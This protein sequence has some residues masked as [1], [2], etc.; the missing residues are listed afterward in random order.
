MSYRKPS[1]TVN[2]VQVTQS[3]PFADPQLKSCV[4][5]KGYYWQDP[6]NDNSVSETEYTGAIAEVQISE[7]TDLEDVVEETLIVEL[8][9]TSG[10]GGGVG[11]VIQLEK[12]A[13]GDYTFSDGTIALV[14]DIE[15]FDDGDDSNAKIRVGFLALQDEIV[16]TFQKISSNKE[17]VDFVG[18]PVPWN[19]LAFGAA[20]MM[21]NSAASTNIVGVQAD[22]DFSPA[23]EKLLNKD[24]Y[25]IAAM[26]GGAE[27]D[28]LSAHVTQMSLPENKRERIA[29][30]SKF[31]TYTGEANTYEDTASSSD[32]ETTSE[33]IQTMASGIGNRRFFHI[34]PDS[35]AVEVVA[36][37][38]TLYSAF[39][40]AVFDD[41]AFKARFISNT[42]INGQTYKAG[43]V[44]TDEIVD[45]LVANGFSEFRVHYP[46]PG[47]YFTTAVA[48]QVVGKQPSD[49]L[50]NRSIVGFAKAYRSN[51]YFTDAQLDTIA[52]G[53]NWILEERAVGAIFNR[54]QLSTDAT[55]IQTRELSITTQL[56]FAAKTYR[57]TVSPL[58]GR[59]VIT[60]S[61][62]QQLEAIMIGVGDDL[63]ENGHVRDVQVLNVFQDELQPDTIKAEISIL[64]LFPLNYIT[65]TIEF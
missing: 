19:P 21:S 24:V 46:V 31:A 28:K 45:E 5:G 36:P 12:G 4:I 54:H 23:I 9:R 40:E 53:G 60:T 35:G 27:A 1:V 10:P 44:I 52:S 48:G 26:T 63:V 15:G 33:S 62:I 42:E 57:D 41:K 61:F 2:Q 39:I 51:D 22:G 13:Q 7:F 29:F 58:I 25:A 32:K 64:P 8:V 11:E 56:D 65:I 34:F 55:T 18:T 50:T 30:A 14:A 6:R 38:A 59:R 47:Y 3:I 20:T 17:L 37:V 49:P 16:N 43:Q